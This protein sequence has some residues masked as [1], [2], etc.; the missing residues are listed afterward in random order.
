MKLFRQQ[1]VL[2]LIAA[3]GTIAATVA[4]VVIKRD[5]Q[6]FSE[7]K[8]S[9]TATS[10]CDQVLAA[11]A[12]VA[13]LTVQVNSDEPQTVKNKERMPL[14]AGDTLKVLNLSYCIPSQT[15]VNK[16]E[17]KAYLFKNE[18]EN[19]KNGLSTPSN[20]PVSSGCHN[21]SNF[22]KSW[23][24]EPG[25]HRVSIPIIKYNGSN[26]VVDKSFYINLDVGE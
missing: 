25:K 13:N 9:A 21:V 15:K 1:L 4:P 17:V 14:K 19:Y 5:K 24:L 6:Y 7:P 23:K 20:F 16:L 26:R 8:P 3:T 12:C 10:I 18:V 11:K 2:A 22:Q